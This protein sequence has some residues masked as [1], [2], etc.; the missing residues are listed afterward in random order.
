MQNVLRR[1][2]IRCLVGRFEGKKG[3]H[4]G[5]LEGG[6]FQKAVLRIHVGEY[7][8]SSKCPILVPWQPQNS[9]VNF[10]SILGNDDLKSEEKRIFTKALL[11]AMA[12]ILPL[13]KG[14]G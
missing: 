10:P 12:Q 14:C 11:T 8:P 9:D 7:D 4:K 13:A 5:F 6:G 1:V 2:L 3:S